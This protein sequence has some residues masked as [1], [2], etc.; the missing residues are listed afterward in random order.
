[1]ESLPA[2]VFL[3]HRVAGQILAIRA[4]FDPDSDHRLGCRPGRPQH[5]N[6]GQSLVVELGHKERL[7][8]SNLLPDLSYPDVLLRNG[9][10]TRLVRTPASVN[11]LPRRAFQARMENL[12][13][14]DHI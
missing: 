6:S 7:L 10:T 5:G 1:M 14:F 11:R 8:G 13:A 9:H 2:F 4:P 12:F 3:G